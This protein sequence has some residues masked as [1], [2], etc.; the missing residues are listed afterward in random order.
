MDRD[1]VRAVNQ[2]RPRDDV[3]SVLSG[4]WRAETRAVPKGR[5]AVAQHTAA[6]SVAARFA[7]L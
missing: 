5:A 2:A 1:F 6:F 4:V 7:P 3:A